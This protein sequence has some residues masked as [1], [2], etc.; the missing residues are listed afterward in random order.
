[1]NFVKNIPVNKEFD[2]EKENWTALKEPNLIMA[3]I[4]A[5]PI[6]FLAAVGIYLLAASLQLTDQYTFRFGFNILLAFLILMP[7]HEIIHA[8]FFPE[9]I[10][11]NHVYFGF[12][13]KGFAFFAYYDR[14]M[15]RNRFLTVCVAPFIGLSILPLIIMNIFGFHS[16]F[17]IDIALV[18]ALSACVDLLNIIL[19]AS[20]VPRNAVIR[21]KGYNSYW[22]AY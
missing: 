8:L 6:A 12:I 13:P 21:N 15:S 16:S 3:Q 20:Q 5:L 14:E 1:M 7:I 2:P 22:K 17:L 9:K 4:I 11:S 18:N 10:T 19:I